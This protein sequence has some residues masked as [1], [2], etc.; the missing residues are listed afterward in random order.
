MH[1]ANSLSRTFQGQEPCLTPDCLQGMPQ[2]LG[3]YKGFVDAVWSNRRRF[4]PVRDLRHGPG[5]A[6]D[7]STYSVESCRAACEG[8]I[9]FGL[10]YV[11]SQGYREACYCDN[12]YGDDPKV[13]HRRRRAFGWTDGPLPDSR[14]DEEDSQGRSLGG[15]KKN[16][17]YTVAGP[18]T[19]QECAVHVANHPGNCSGTFFNWRAEGQGSHCGSVSPGTNCEAPSPS[20]GMHGCVK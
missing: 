10:Q 20:P 7:G 2:Y 9:Y 1:Q 14:C 3:C 13:T 16:A 18:N 5:L 11:A 8:Y 19:A 6:A 4:G 15:D 17:I 12:S